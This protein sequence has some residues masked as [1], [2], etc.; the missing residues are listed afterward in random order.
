MRYFFGFR[1]VAFLLFSVVIPCSGARASCSVT[2]E[3]A[4]PGGDPLPG[5]DIILTGTTLGASAGPDGKFSMRGLPRGRYEFVVSRV[6]YKRATRILDLEDGK[7]VEIDFILH[8]EPLIL[9]ELIVTARLERSYP[10]SLLVEKKAPDAA[11]IDSGALLK[12]IPG[13]STVKKGG[14]GQDPVL[15]GFSEDQIC[16]LL[17]G[18]AKTACA[19]PNRMDPPTSHIQAEDIEKIEVFKGPFTVRYGEAP[20]GL[21][22]VVLKKPDPS[23]SL[24][25]GRAEFGY[26]PDH[27]GIMGRISATSTLDDRFALFLGGGYREEGDYRDGDGGV[28][29]AGVKVSD[30]AIKGRYDPGSRLRVQATFRSSD[31]RDA[32][33]PALPMDMD[34]DIFRL[35]SLD[36]SS[37]FRGGFVEK[38][39]GSVYL[40]TVDHVMSNNES[41]PSWDMV[42]AVA[43]IEARTFG[44]RCETRFRPPAFGTV[45]SGFDFI[46]T[47][48]NGARV[49]DFV[50]PQKPT[51]IDRIWPDAVQNRAGAFSECKIPLAEDVSLLAGFRLGWASYEASGADSLFFE[52]SGGSPDSLESLDFL[53]AAHVSFMWRVAPDLELSLSAGAGSRAGSLTEKYINRFQIGLDNYE[54]LGDPG[55]KPE[56]NYQ[57]ELG[58]SFSGD[59]LEADCSVYLSF[60]TG[61]ITGFVDTLSTDP[62][63]VVVKRFG[64]LD[65]ARLEGGEISTRYKFDRGFYL[66]GSLSYTRGTNLDDATPLPEI[67]PLEVN[68]LLG[69]E[70]WKKR[71]RVELDGRFVAPQNRVSSSFAEQ[72]TPGFAVFGSVLEL[73][74]FDSI[75]IITGVDNIFD[76]TYSEHLNRCEKITG[77]EP[78]P[79]E[80][81]S[82]YTR[83][84][85]SW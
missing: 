2:G 63:P 17:D 13:I 81:R 33:F 9:D 23:G 20:G 47:W 79:E 75:R 49:K 5:A 84:S 65:I 18:A 15:R 36:V 24:F 70:H 7:D 1:I 32:P 28:V 69:Y 42:H 50:S 51:A 76:E 71:V 21:I 16:I 3:V 34:K 58:A 85:F 40:T 10:A 46:S 82:I 19:C 45:W 44:G 61:A 27:E 26:E 4:D 80:G 83:L 35:Y 52:Y 54:Y 67:P 66:A 78:I 8:A 48:K 56:I 38:L 59:R 31:T 57:S 14:A 62:D 64:N 41:K 30:Y 6:G 29:N 72:E 77:G 12:T 39:D 74:F 25:G 60:L 68:M 22:N 73:R 37:D 43:D 55:L 53:P 11:I